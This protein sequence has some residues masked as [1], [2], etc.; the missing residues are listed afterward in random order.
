MKTA[1]RVYTVIREA[2]YDASVQKFRCF[3]D[4]HPDV[5]NDLI[6]TF[7]PRFD[8]PWEADERECMIGFIK[9]GGFVYL[10]PVAPDTKKYLRE[11]HILKTSGGCLQGIVKKH[12]TLINY[13]FN[14]NS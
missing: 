5:A 8:Q 12:Y 4:E 10:F 14:F 13:I 7:D 6:S 2:L 11:K 9:N 1:H 3:P